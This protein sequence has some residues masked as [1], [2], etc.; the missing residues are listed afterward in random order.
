MGAI[1][2]RKRIKAATIIIVLKK[3]WEGF[4]KVQIKEAADKVI[5]FEFD[6]EDT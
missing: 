1:I 2:E 3:T 6:D 5:M 4:G